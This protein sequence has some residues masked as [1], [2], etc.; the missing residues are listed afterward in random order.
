MDEWMNG[1]IFLAYPASTRW[2]DKVFWHSYFP[3]KI[4]SCFVGRAMFSVRRCGEQSW[5]PKKTKKPLVLP[6]RKRPTRIER[7]SMIVKLSVAL[8][9]LCGWFKDKMNSVHCIQCGSH[10]NTERF[11]PVTRKMQ[12]NVW[13]SFFCCW[14]CW[15]CSWILRS[16]VGF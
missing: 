6:I 11:E 3:I 13:I 9:L 14:C 2:I 15:L 1:F 12:F 16:L 5:N 7:F 8:C 10:N 4:L